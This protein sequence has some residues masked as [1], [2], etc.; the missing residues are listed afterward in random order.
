MQLTDQLL[1]T[2]GQLRY[3]GSLDRG[4]AIYDEA[5][6]IISRQGCIEHVYISA[7]W[8]SCSACIQRQFYARQ[9]LGLLPQPQLGCGTAAVQQQL[10]FRDNLKCGCSAGGAACSLGSCSRNEGAAAASA[11]GYGCRVRVWLQL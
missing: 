10:A 7:R 5:H 9:R 1:Y 3:V 8:C 2:A 4:R 6:S 11:L